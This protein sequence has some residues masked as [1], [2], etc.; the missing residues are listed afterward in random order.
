MRK[1]NFKV[2]YTL[3]ASIFILGLVQIGLNISAQVPIIENAI[4]QGA[5]SKSI[6][7]YLWLQ[8]I[9]LLLGSIITT[10]GLGSILLGIASIKKESFLNMSLD[11]IHPD[12]ISN[13]PEPTIIDNDDK[14]EDLLEEFVLVD[15]S[16]DKTEESVQEINDEKV[17]D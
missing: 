12:L 1:M 3:A 9:P 11:P 6:A 15:E 13:E 5:N 7:N 4:M 8:V 10:L 17:V 2:F 16:D 14:A